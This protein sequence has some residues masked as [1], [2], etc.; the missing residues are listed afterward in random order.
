MNNIVI[1]RAPVESSCIA[2][3]G[4][5]DTAKTLEVEFRSGAVY[6]YF[7]VPPE[8]HLALMG[9]ASKGAYLNR[10]IKGRHAETRQQP[11]RSSTPA[12]R[13]EAARARST[14]LAEVRRR[15]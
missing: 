15:S 2:S 1:A 7:G 13:S 12:R 8:T 3:V 10:Y 4:Y 11:Q 6:R 9:A 5:A 14:A